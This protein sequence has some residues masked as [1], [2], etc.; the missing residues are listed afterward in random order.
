[1]AKG[2]TKWS[3]ALPLAVGFG[4][5]T[6]LLAGLGLWSVKTQ[7]AGAVV[8]PGVVEVESDLQVIQHPDGGV[9]GEILARDGDTVG[10]GEVLL[11]LDGT[12]LNSELA[13]VEAQLL[14]IFARKAR[15]EA[16]RDGKDAPDF[17]GAPDYVSLASDALAE[18]IEGQRNLFSARRSTLEQR[19]RLL[20]EQ[21]VQIDSQIEGTEAQLTGLERQI[22]LMRLELVDVQSLF[23][24]Q[25]VQAT[26]LLELQRAEANLEGEIG[27]L[28]ARTAE[29][30]TRISA[31]EIERL[32]LY[33]QRRED[34]ISELRDLRVSEVELAERRLELLE[35]LSRLEVKAPVEGTV[36]GSTV[37]A[38]Q[39][40]IRPADPMMYLVPGDQPLQVSA[41]VDPVHI[42][43]VYPGQEAALMFTTFNS[44]NTPSVP[45][46]I[47]RLSAD[48]D[49][50]EATGVAYYEAVI[51]PD[52]ETL[53]SLNHVTL[54]PGM[55]VETFLKTED[56]TPLDYLTHPLTVYFNRAFRED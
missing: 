13:I 20:T 36:F 33:E 52:A 39:S 7:I 56:R 43:Q 38:V 51:R 11:R 1:M 30:R 46:E 55:P 53:A 37:F 19:A 22:D 15:L 28:V 27:N 4:A 18:Q 17:S 6:L 21:K 42:E 31:L 10:A 8:A 29:A 14:E 34:A 5:I 3:A 49:I 23:D 25:L 54:L 12:F 50:D 40:V 44:R 35:R 41:R 45:G 24:R 9:V 48:A 47:V 26:R 16:E 2:A 32:G